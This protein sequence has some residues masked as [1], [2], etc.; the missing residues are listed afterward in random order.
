MQGEK[1]QW[2]NRNE[3]EVLLNPN[4]SPQE[5]ACISDRLKTLTA[6]WNKVCK[7]FFVINKQALYVFIL[8][9]SC[10]IYVTAQVDVGRDSQ[11]LVVS[12]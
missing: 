3:Q 6:K 9:V 11:G 2:L 10:R 4:I 5:K 7:Y 12:K 1:L 8:T